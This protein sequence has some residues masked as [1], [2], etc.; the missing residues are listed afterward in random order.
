MSAIV[1]KGP[2]EDGATLVENPY[3]DIIVPPP[4]VREVIDKTAQF[5]AKNGVEFEKRMMQ[6]ANAN[7]RFGFLFPNHGYRDYYD[8]KLQEVREG[9]VRTL[10]PV[11]PDVVKKV[12]EREAA[13]QEKRLALKNAA[14]GQ[15]SGFEALELDE[16]EDF[17]GSGETNIGLT[18][19][20]MERFSLIRP[21]VGAE[22]DEVI[23]LV[24]RFAA[25]SGQAFVS[26]LSQRERGNNAFDFLKASHPSHGYFRSLMDSYARIIKLNREGE[27]EFFTKSRLRV[28]SRQAAMAS[29]SADEDLKAPLYG[30]KLVRKLLAQMY[31]RQKHY[32]K[33]NEE[34]RKKEEAE[35][36]DKAAM[37]SILWDRFVVVE[38][39]T[40]TDADEQLPLP[41]PDWTVHATPPEEP[42]QTAQ[43]TPSETA[44]KPATKPPPPP[45]PVAVVQPVAAVTA[46]VDGEEQKIILRPDYVRRP[47]R[48]VANN[49]YFKCPITGQLVLAEEMSSHLKVLLLDKQWKK[50]RDDLLTKALADSA[51]APDSDIETN[52]ANFVLKRPDLFGTVEDEIH[53][54]I[55]RPDTITKKSRLG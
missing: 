55:I 52:I 25:C 5:V 43:D 24:A 9:K 15:G 12:W 6:E 4:A 10:V 32:A 50:Q 36:A 47:K 54:H 16:N 38:T 46:Q 27:D 31:V 11:V 53:E 44:T 7:E 33:I 39:I 37:A 2:A 28:I 34:K 21:N 14:E 20:G 45:P 49:K 35:A 41:A 40:F 30:E 13:A 8:R 1:A 51:Y 19:G 22:E 29:C 17:M 18:G 48:A 26:G 3:A 23:K 42:V